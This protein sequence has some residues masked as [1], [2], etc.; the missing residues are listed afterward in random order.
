MLSAG[1][2]TATVKGRL[3]SFTT[4]R[5]GIDA[6]DTAL[7]V[8]VLSSAF[9]FCVEDIRVYSSDNA[10]IAIHCPTDATTALAGTTV[11]GTALDRDFSNTSL[12]EAK[13]DET[14]LSQGTI[15]QADYVKGGEPSSIYDFGGGLVIPFGK[16]IAVDSVHGTGDIMVTIRGYFKVPSQ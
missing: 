1:A 5:V 6:N 12:A 3:V 7:L 2:L 11:V 16:S 9:D 15:I 10:E 13:G 4:T 14:A 8:R